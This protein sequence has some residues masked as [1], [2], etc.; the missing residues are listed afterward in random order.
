VDARGY[1]DERGEVGGF[2]SAHGKVRGGVCVGGGRR[3]GAAAAAGA[4]ACLQPRG[5][6]QP[7]PTRGASPR[8][9]CTPHPHPHP[10]PNRQVNIVQQINHDGEVNRARAMPQDK[11]KIATKTVSAEV[12]RGGAGPAAG[13]Q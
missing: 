6:A 1:D 12:R 10:H 3:A 8:R 7:V 13:S 5:S 4:P 11:F 9:R 2:G